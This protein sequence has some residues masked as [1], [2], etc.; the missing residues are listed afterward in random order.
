[1]LQAEKQV[2]LQ[3]FRLYHNEKEMSDLEKEI[4][5]KQA[6]LE[7]IEKRKE[8]AEEVLKEKKKEF[9]RVSREMSKLEQDIREMVSCWL[10]AGVGLIY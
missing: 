9:N 1:M 10:V 6:D 2:E 5:K 8:K 3:L 4:R 7:K